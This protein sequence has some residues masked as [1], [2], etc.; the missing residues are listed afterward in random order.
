MSRP[1]QSKS[2]SKSTSKVEY[3]L[4]AW[5]V[6]VFALYLAQFRGM[7]KPILGILTGS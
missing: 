1:L 2:Q 5:V 7:I 3:A 4:I 6:I